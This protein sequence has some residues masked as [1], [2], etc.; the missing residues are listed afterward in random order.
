[1]CVCVCVC[2]GGGGGGLVPSPGA[3]C[4]NFVGSISLNFLC[5]PIFNTMQLW[6][7]PKTY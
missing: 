7:G 2:V 5:L 6:L 1:M 4:I 3:S